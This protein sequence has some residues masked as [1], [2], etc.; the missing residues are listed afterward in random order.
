MSKKDTTNNKHN[1]TV[2]RVIESNRVPE[3]AVYN[4][5]AYHNEWRCKD[6]SGIVIG[7]VSEKVV[8]ACPSMFIWG[9]VEKS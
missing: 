8:D 7:T 1:R 2:I 3:G 4:Y 9:D 5:S 6:S